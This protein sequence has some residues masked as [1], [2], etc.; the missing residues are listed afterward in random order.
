MRFGK[1]CVRSSSFRDSECLGDFFTPDPPNSAEVEEE[2][3]EGAEERAAECV[4]TRMT[5]G[6]GEILEEEMRR[7]QTE[8]LEHARGLEESKRRRMMESRLRKNGQ[9]RWERLL[10]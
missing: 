5:G 4:P 2:E 10:F 9:R 3:G 8:R 1:V 7:S 6:R